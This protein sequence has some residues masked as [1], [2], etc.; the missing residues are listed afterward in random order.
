MR[1]K[2]LI[3]A[4]AIALSQWLVAQHYRYVFGVPYNQNIKFISDDGDGVYT[5]AGAGDYSGNNNPGYLAVWDDSSLEVKNYPG[6]SDLGSEHSAD[7]YMA[8]TKNGNTYAVGT[9]ANDGVS[10]WGSV[11]KYQPNQSN[12]SDEKV[13]YGAQQSYIYKVHN[14][15]Y[16]ILWLDQYYRADWSDYSFNH[17]EGWYFAKL[18]E[19][20]LSLDWVVYLGTTSNGWFPAVSDETTNRLR[21]RPIIYI[22]ATGT[23]ALHVLRL[24]N[25]SDPANGVPP[26]Y[27][28]LWEFDPATGSN[29]GVI[30][31][32]FEPGGAYQYGEHRWWVIGDTLYHQKHYNLTDS[33]DRAGHLEMWV[34]NDTLATHWSDTGFTLVAKTDWGNWDLWQSQAIDLGKLQDGRILTTYAVYL[35]E[36]LGHIKIER[37]GLGGLDAWIHQDSIAV[38][39]G[40]G[41]DSVGV[42]LIGEY[43]HGEELRLNPNGAHVVKGFD[44]LYYTGVH[45]DWWEPRVQ[46]STLVLEDGQV[47][48]ENDPIDTG[49]VQVPAGYTFLGATPVLVS[50]RPSDNGRKYFRAGAQRDF[51]DG[52][53][54]ELAF[55]VYLLEESQ[56]N[57]T[58]LGVH[59][60]ELR[61]LK[62]YPNPVSDWL[63][64]EAEEGIEEL[65]LFNLGGALV[66]SAQ[67]G[68]LF[69]G[70]LP[71]GVYFLEVRN[72]KGYGVVRII[73]R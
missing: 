12:Y 6:R 36:T 45:N 28:E 55:R 60:A 30:A 31:Q 46:E 42:A 27:T 34:P 20:D 17:G 67:G 48:E 39:T 3:T 1:T 72:R 7:A 56:V 57:S 44:N 9:V 62:V 13:V 23:I 35:N 19:N 73:K 29:L 54:V 26:Q 58:A 51:P 69:V 32:G 64:A 8:L 38:M 50:N 33:Q 59:S 52:S 37:A 2:L 25:N 71:A 24:E 14:E 5:V 40:V 22:P 11:R 43:S 63:T 61:G 21:R 70:D 16:L 65:R 41:T 4:L 15:L 18:N 66:K 49:W 68:S 47:P 53:R 10:F